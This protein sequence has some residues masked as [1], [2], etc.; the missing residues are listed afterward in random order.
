[1]PTAKICMDSAPQLHVLVAG[2]DDLLLHCMLSFLDNP[3]LASCVPMS[4]RFCRVARM[5]MD[6][7]VNC[8]RALLWS[9]EQDMVPS[10]WYLLLDGRVDPSSSGN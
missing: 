4:R 9:C 1:M 3:V 6:P 7:A 2:E 5:C 10:V 8:S